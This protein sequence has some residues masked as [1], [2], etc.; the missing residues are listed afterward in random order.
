MPVAVK[1]RQ[2][3]FMAWER[4]KPQ[5]KW[6]Q[7]QHVFT[8]G[9]TGTGKSTVA[10]EF[11]GRRSQVVVCV[12]KGMDPIFDGPYYNEYKEMQTWRPGRNDRILLR[13]ANMRTLRETRDNKKR[14][15]AEMFD[16][17]LLVRGNWCIDV[18]ETHY[19]SK[20]LGLRDEITD[21]LEQGRSAGISM[22]NNTQRPADIP[23]SI[24]VNSTHAFLFQAQEDYDLQRLANLA[25]KHTNAQEMR[26]NLDALDSFR[27]HELVYLDR[28]G[29]I[30]PV[31]TIVTKKG[32]KKGDAK[33][34]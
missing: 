1:L 22:W 34:R 26:A 4:L 5:I 25:N 6:Q 13:P 10:G 20:T 32:S 23:L 12:S 11:L 8:C 30:P 24:Y 19:M 18:D 28:T 33:K 9:G 17:V 2:Y 7:G 3:P 16:N 29:V 21:I 27:T 15:F 31:R 14:V